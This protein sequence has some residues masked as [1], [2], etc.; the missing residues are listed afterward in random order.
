MNSL[1]CNLNFWNNPSTKDAYRLTITTL[2]VEV[3]ATVG[4]IHLFKVNSACI[5]QYWNDNILIIMNDTL[6]E[7]TL[8]T[9][10]VFANRILVHH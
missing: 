10:L 9:A 2:V 7:C 8:F 1:L 5:L 4:G 3:L 6:S